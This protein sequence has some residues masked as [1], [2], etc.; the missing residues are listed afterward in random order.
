M[1][2]F[3]PHR[4]TPVSATHELIAEVIAS[5]P[6]A[7]NGEQFAILGPDD[8]TYIQTLLTP[9]G[10]VLQ[11]QEGSAERHFES[12]RTDLRE[13]EVVEAFGAYLDGNVAWRWP[14]EWR[15]V[16]VR[17]ESYRMGLWVGRLVGRLFGGPRP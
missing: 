7:P 10:F 13:T 14:I 12:T 15:Q 5:L 4:G 6:A 11:Y 2:L 1:N 16:E 17:P 9:N 8:Q 3:A